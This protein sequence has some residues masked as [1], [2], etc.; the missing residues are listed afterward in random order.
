MFSNNSN[1]CRRQVI[2]DEEFVGGRS[3]SGGCS[4]FRGRLC[5]W[6]GLLRLGAPDTTN[7]HKKQVTSAPHPVT[8]AAATKPTLQQKMPPQLLSRPKS[9]PIP[10]PPD[11]GAPEPAHTSAAPLD[12]QKKGSL[13]KLL[14]NM[15]AGSGSGAGAGAGKPP[16]MPSGSAIKILDR[17]MTSVAATAAAVNNPTAE[18]TPDLLEALL[19]S[20]DDA[21]E[22]SSASKSNSAASSDGA[23]KKAPVVIERAVSDGSGIAALAAAAGA[24]EEG[25]KYDP[26]NPFTLPLPMP[27]AMMPM[28]Y[29]PAPGQTGNAAKAMKVPLVAHSQ[30]LPSPTKQRGP[31]PSKQRVPSPNKQRTQQQAQTQ[32]TAAPAAAAKESKQAGQAKGTKPAKKDAKGAKEATQPA[33]QPASGAPVKDI[34]TLRKIGLSFSSNAATAPSDSSAAPGAAPAEPASETTEQPAASKGSSKGGKV[35]IMDKL[36]AA[37]RTMKQSMDAEKKTTENA[38]ENPSSSSSSAASAPA[39]TADS[40][41]SVDQLAVSVT[42]LEMNARNNPPPP[43]PADTNENKPAADNAAAGAASTAAATVPKSAPSTL[44]VPSKLLMAKKK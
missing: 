21:V 4:Q 38:P 40:S 39:P 37:K 28:G 3:L 20:V 7:V 5:P 16:T 23:E 9:A 11:P 15:G 1:S 33:Q 2:F 6:S 22:G 32:A 41:P 25:N 8:L 10:V 31:S 17:P 43:P 34:S 35:S 27:P 42:Q 19:G 29:P 14:P 13:S 18:F 24:N 30:R 26:S 44:L 36:A 12:Q